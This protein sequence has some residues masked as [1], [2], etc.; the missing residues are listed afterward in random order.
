MAYKRSRVTLAS[1]QVIVNEAIAKAVAEVTR[2]TIQAMA[3]AMAEGPLSVAG[4]KI[5]VPAMKEPSFNWEEDDK[6]SKLKIFRLDINNML[7]MYNAP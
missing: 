7:T 1:E 4:A 2:A 6:Y 3:A 5:G